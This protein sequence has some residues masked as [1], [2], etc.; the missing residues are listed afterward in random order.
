[1]SKKSVV[2]SGS[3]IEV[4]GSYFTW[5]IRSRVPKGSALGSVLFK[6]FVNDLNQTLIESS[7]YMKLKGSVDN[8]NDRTVI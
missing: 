2:K 3:E 5:L 6:V 7:G 1:M 4:G 8:L